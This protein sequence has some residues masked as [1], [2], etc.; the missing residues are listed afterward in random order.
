MST[1]TPTDAIQIRAVAQLPDDGRAGTFTGEGGGH[2]EM[3]TRAC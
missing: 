3:Y 2:A 1:A